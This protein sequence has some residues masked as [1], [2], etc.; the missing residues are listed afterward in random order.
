MIAVDAKKL[1]DIYGKCS[2]MSAINT[3]NARR[4]PATRGEATFVPHATWLESGWLTETMALGIPT[5][6][7]SHPPVELTVCGS[8]PDIAKHNNNDYIWL[9]WNSS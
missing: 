9:D 4:R 3:G 6:P 2:F 7:R 5:R 1:L 8:I